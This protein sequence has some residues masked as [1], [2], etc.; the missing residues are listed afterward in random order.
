[1]SITFIIILVVFISWISRSFSDFVL[2]ALAVLVTVII[3]QRMDAETVTAK[4]K[5]VDSTPSI[6][7]PPM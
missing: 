1:M 5:H 6:T 7:S 3:M 2:Y 4:V